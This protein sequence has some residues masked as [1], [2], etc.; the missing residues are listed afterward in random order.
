[1]EKYRAASK[2]VH[3]IFQEYTSLIEP[4]SLDEAFLDVTNSD[5]L[6]GSA[7]LIAREIRQKVKERVGITISAGMRQTNSW[8]KSPRIG[9]SQTESSL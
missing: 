5:H 2:S 3:Q 1:M 8:Q 4:L 6:E 7:T 9:T